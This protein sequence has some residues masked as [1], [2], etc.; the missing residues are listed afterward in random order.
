VFEGAKGAGDPFGAGLAV[1]ELLGIAFPDANI[2]R[3]M[4]SA[5]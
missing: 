2:E 5:I 4:A 1:V 3:I